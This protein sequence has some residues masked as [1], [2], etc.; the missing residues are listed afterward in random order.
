M[1]L[2]ELRYFLAVAEEQSITR[3]AERLYIAQPSLSRQMQ[4]LE[5]EV[6]N[7]LLVRGGRKIGLTETGKLLRKRAQ[8]LLELYEKTEAELAA[9][10]TEVSGD[11]YI[12]GGES[13]AVR[14]V[15]AAAKTV[16]D[17]FPGIRFHFFSGDAPA[18][19]EKLD[20]GLLDFGVLIDAPAL[21]GY[22][23]LPLPLSDRWG[24]LMRRDSPL[25]AHG[26]IRP[27][28]LA[29]QPLVCSDQ[30]VAKGLVAGWLG[31]PPEQMCVAA[32]YN[33][34]YVASE[35]VAEGFGYAVGLDG[36][37]ATDGERELCFRPLEPALETRLDVVWKKHQVFSPA[38]AKFLEALRASLAR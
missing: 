35:L 25:A 23:A 4:N 1:E 3:A 34:L 11:V 14:T 8:E 29:G 15:A 22:D 18:V 7:P 20:K 10:R 38:G 5:K 33:L 32:T 37:I 19:L 13:Y 28:D 27:E 30:S 21:S 6:G 9:P 17:R 16:R 26:S 36:I 2:R 24:V 31:I 12:G